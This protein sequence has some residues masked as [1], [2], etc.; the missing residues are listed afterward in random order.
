MGEYSGRAVSGLKG[1]DIYDILKGEI[2]NLKLQPGQAISEPET[3]ARFG[4]SRT[5]VREA[6]RKMENERLLEVK[7]KVGT[8]VARIQMKKV[9]DVLYIREAVEAYIYQTLSK[10]MEAHSI[11]KMSILLAKQKLLLDEESDS[12]EGAAKFLA[13]DNQFHKELFEIAGKSGVW[14]ILME[15]CFDY[16][17]ARVFLNVSH[18]LHMRENYREHELLLTYLVEGRLE[19]LL[20]HNKTHLYGGVSRIFQALKDHPEYFDE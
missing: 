17:R 18:N 6:F 9:F 16:E 11:Q 14:E 7:P 1:N 5:P 2:L 3:A 4:M 12:Q 13:L 19:E 20:E 10:N 8:R 15:S